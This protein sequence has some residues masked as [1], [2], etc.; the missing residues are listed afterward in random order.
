MI[1]CDLPEFSGISEEILGRGGVLRFQAYGGSMH[2]FVRNGDIVEV[3]PIIPGQVR[4]GD[5]ILFKDGPQSMLAHRVIRRMKN[6]KG[7]CFITKG[8]S[9]SNADSPVAPE[10]V[11]GRL[12]RIERNSRVMNLTAQGR[13]K[14]AV[15]FAAISFFSYFFY[16]L[17][18]W[19]KRFAFRIIRKSYRVL[20][21]FKVFR[22]LR[23]SFFFNEINYSVLEP[24]DYLALA[25]FYGDEKRPGM[26]ERLK[27]LKEILTA[28]E[29]KGYY[30][31]VRIRNRI[32]AVTGA[33]PH[34]GES[35]DVWW[36]DSL[37]VRTFCRGLGLGRGLVRQALILA[38][39]NGVRFLHLL[40]DEREKTARCL[41]KSLGFKDTVLPELEDWLAK[42]RKIRNRR[43]RVM[44][45]NLQDY[46]P[47][48]DAQDVYQVNDYLRGIAVGVKGNKHSLSLL[49]KELLFD[50]ACR[51][52]LAPLIGSVLLQEQEEKENISWQNKFRNVYLAN[53][54]RNVLITEKMKKICGQFNAN[55][56]KVMVLKGPFLGE[57]IYK[58]AGTRPMGDLDLLIEKKDISAADRLLRA[59]G[60]FTLEGAVA[61]AGRNENSTINT[62]QYKESGGD[63][64][65]VHLHWHLI[66]CTW[67]LNYLVSKMDMSR[68]WEQAVPVKMSGIDLCSLLPEHL[69]LYLCSHYLTH[70]FR[71]LIL[72]ADI[73]RVMDV[74]GDD[75]SA[76]RLWQEAERLGMQEMFFGALYFL[77]LSG[78]KDI[79]GRF[80]LAEEKFSGVK[81]LC[82]FG[83]T[84]GGKTLR[85]AAYL[86]CLLG[87]KGLKGKLYYVFRTFFPGK[88]VLAHNFGLLPEKIGFGHYLRRLRK[89]LGIKRRIFKT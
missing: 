53:C 60:Y 57:F 15:F 77:T 48:G 25:Y 80:A 23:R 51:E 67:P 13:R 44:R 84:H 24:K 22:L 40:V 26:P 52:K 42:E 46:T 4:A 78:R 1:R 37:Q 63:N 59:N 62:L 75:L 20:L 54:A 50:V 49:N 83:F 55:G 33:G 72:T 65:F 36:L 88:E 28:P 87:Q 86:I 30:L 82:D 19:T 3:E 45:A 9:A 10:R 89:T 58:D 74:Y 69:L 34:Q 7:L 64:F 18:G 81:R 70:G 14:L 38:K 71:P 41:Y 8:D 35:P 2:P 47:G 32:V 56:L 79:F 16:P 61:A 43:L 5:I 66:N 17:L 85:A 21:N 27:E 73:C 29:K 12:R 11:L 39:E 68:V 31:A 6:E 76:G